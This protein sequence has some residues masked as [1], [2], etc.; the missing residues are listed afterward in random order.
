MLRGGG[1][2]IVPFLCGT[3]NLHLNEEE[4]NE[5]SRNEVDS[6]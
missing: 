2:V 4:G 5:K 3:T 6:S 1:V